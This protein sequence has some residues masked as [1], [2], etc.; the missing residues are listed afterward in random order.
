ML[1]FNI[2]GFDPRSITRYKYIHPHDGD[3][4]DPDLLGATFAMLPAT[5]GCIASFF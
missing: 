1:P 4:G 5:I 3:V 2:K